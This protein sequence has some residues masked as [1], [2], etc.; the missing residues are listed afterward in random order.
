MIFLF[1][2]DE[3]LEEVGTGYHN[4]NGTFSRRTYFENLDGSEIRFLRDI[5]IQVGT[6]I[7]KH[8][9]AGEEELF[10]FISGNG[11]VIMNDERRK[12]GP[13]VVLLTLPGNF[14]GVE[15]DG[16]TDLRFISICINNPLK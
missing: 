16:E 1:H 5:T 10:F 13:G 2:P 9:H 6:V 15:N 11:T 12:V 3:S 4:G 7:G 8:S 14:H